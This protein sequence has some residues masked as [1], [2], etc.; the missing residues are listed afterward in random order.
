MI[1]I[2]IIGA[3]GSMGTRAC[4]RLGIDT[5][6]RLLYVES[7]ELGQQRL[8][9]RGLEPANLHAAAVEADVVL[10]A[11]PDRL[12]QRVAEDVVPRMKSGAMI[13][14]LDPAAPHA[15][16][17]PIR[18]ELSYFVTHPAHPPVTGKG[19]ATKRASPRGPYFSTSPALFSVRL[20]N[21]S[22][23]VCHSRNCRK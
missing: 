14:C 23:K 11:V 5:A 19:I 15:G 10:L 3:A 13:I 22:K 8:R 4:N 6:Y 7:G 17:L 12:I 21:H 16:R 9:E 18:G 20:N 2:A 1:T